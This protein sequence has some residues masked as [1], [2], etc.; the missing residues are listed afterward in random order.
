[1]FKF[2]RSTGIIKVD[3]AVSTNLMSSSV[4]FVILNAFTTNNSL[5]SGNPAV[6]VFL[7]TELPTET[8]LTIAK[9]F[10]QPI[11]SFVYTVGDHEIDKRTAT[12]AIR[13]FTVEIEIQLC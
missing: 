5:A 11:A 3:G 12:F 7:Q 4:R 13:W 6:T 9:N 8:L 1:M 2:D 10:N